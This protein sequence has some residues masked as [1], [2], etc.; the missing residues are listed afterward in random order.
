MPQ[1]V[2]PFSSK[3]HS[4]AYTYLLANDYVSCFFGKKVNDETTKQRIMEIKATFTTLGDEAELSL[5]NVFN[6][7][8]ISLLPVSED[9][10]Q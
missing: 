5:V 3:R 8:I 9:W 1:V 4:L 2:L 6:I 10:S 7:G